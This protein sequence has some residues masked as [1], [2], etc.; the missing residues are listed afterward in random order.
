MVRVDGYL[1]GVYGRLMTVK[2]S[3]YGIRGPWV[4]AKCGACGN[5]RPC[6]EYALGYGEDVDH[7]TI[8][9]PCLVKDIERDEKQRAEEQREG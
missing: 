1:D 3:A 8:C 6:L 5:E 7:D 4:D 9:V 2:L